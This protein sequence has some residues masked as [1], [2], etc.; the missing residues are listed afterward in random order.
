MN[1]YDGRNTPT[2]NSSPVKSE[3]PVKKLKNMIPK[4]KRG[5]VIDNFLNAPLFTNLEFV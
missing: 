2:G 4:A 5:D 3:T 1:I